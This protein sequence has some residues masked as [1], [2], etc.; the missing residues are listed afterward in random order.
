M[1]PSSNSLHEYES[2]ALLVEDQDDLDIISALVQDGLLKK[3]NIRWIKKR[4][5]FSLLIN[6]F[7]WEQ[8]TKEMRKTVPCDRVQT[9]LTFD[10]VLR[11]LSLGV[12][13]AL[14]NQI[15]SLLRIEF[16]AKE[17]CDEIKLVFSGN[18]IIRLKIE[19]LRVALRDL[20]PVDGLKTGTVPNHD[21]RI[22]Q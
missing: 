15:L 1:T 10:G 11:V 4:R 17:I 6:R 9:V 16:V 13:N 21:F 19:F 22:D 20:S 12:E 3:A 18:I 7:R 2:L 5:R 8:V 14:E